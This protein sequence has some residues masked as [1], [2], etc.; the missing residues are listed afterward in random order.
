MG[1][2][3][4]RNS[5][6]AKRFSGLMLGAL[7]GVLIVCL[8]MTM[9]LSEGRR[10]PGDFDSIEDSISSTKDDVNALAAVTP[11]PPLTVSWSKL[12]AASALHGAEIIYLG[13]DAGSSQQLYS[14]PLKNW[15][16]SMVGDKSLVPSLLNRLQSEIPVFVYG[17]KIDESNATITFTVVGT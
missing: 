11:L 12:S 10:L 15:S 14:G 6:T 3:T 7:A 9:T 5:L 16:G 2:L 1:K 8:K 17:Y 13:N 4:R